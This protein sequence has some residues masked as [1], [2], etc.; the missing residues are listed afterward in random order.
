VL[1]AGLVGRLAELGWD[2]RLRGS[3]TAMVL[4]LVVVFGLGMVWLSIAASLTV[5]QTL[6]YGLWPFIPGEII[7][8]VIAAGLLP[9]GWRLVERRDHDL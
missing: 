8:L 6:Q 3:I 9:I 4:G 2:R 5:S 1:A 7:K